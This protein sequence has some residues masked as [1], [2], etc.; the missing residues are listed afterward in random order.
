MIAEIAMRLAFLLKSTDPDGAPL[1]HVDDDVRIEQVAQ[2][3]S[4]ALL[5]EGLRAR[6]AKIAKATA[7]AIQKKAVPGT[8]HGRMMR[9][10]WR[11]STLRTP[12][13]RR[14]DRASARLGIR[15]VVDKRSGADGHGA[16][17]QTSR[18]AVQNLCDRTW[19]AATVVRG[20]GEHWVVRA[21]GRRKPSEA[22]AAVPCQ[23][24]GQLFGSACWISVQGRPISFK[25]VCGT[26]ALPVAATP[27]R[28][29]LP[30]TIPTTMLTY[31]ISTL[32]ALQLVARWP[33]TGTG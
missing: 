2:H 11:A 29:S 32:V 15:T 13:G 28:I 24:Q 21:D 1:Q 23:T 22:G 8:A 20:C 7:R 9:F 4:Q 17:L 33:S 18:P 3:Q 19:Q 25:H 30:G 6:L 12:S 14:N 27:L 31:P 16:E 10:P 5:T 26:A